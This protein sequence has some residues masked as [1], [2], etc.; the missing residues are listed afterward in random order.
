[1][2]HEID[3]SKSRCPSRVSRGSPQN[4]TALSGAPAV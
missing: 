2:K 4:G 3:E 1:M